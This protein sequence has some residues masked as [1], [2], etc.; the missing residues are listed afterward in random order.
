MNTEAKY[1]IGEDKYQV[2]TVEKSAPPQG[3]ETGNWFRYVI[4]QGKSKIEGIK[5]GT[6]Q[7]VT[8]H[9]HTMVDDLNTR[10]TKGGSFYAPRHRK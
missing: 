9:A 3:I 8:D 6:L 10:A 7:A 2:V 4:G 1:I 5:C